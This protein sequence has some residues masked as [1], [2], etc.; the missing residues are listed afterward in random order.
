MTQAVSKNS[1]RANCEFDGDGVYELR[2]RNH[3]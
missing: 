1:D 3:L 2:Y